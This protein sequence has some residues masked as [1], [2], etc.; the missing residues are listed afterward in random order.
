[1]VTVKLGV[2]PVLIALALAAAFVWAVW[3]SKKE[4]AKVG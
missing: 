4:T 3:Q 2:V 1:V